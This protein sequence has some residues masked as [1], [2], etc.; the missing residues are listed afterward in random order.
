MGN[1][2][3]IRNKTRRKT[4]CRG[5]SVINVESISQGKKMRQKRKKRKSSTFARVEEILSKGQ[6]ILLLPDPSEESIVVSLDDPPEVQRDISHLSD[7]ILQSIFWYFTLKERCTVLS[8][9]CKRWYHISKNPLFWRDLEFS[10][11]KVPTMTIMQLIRGCPQ[12]R[13]L[14]L[15]RV[16]EAAVIIQELCREKT[17]LTELTLRYCTMN[18]I[19]SIHV[20]LQMLTSLPDLQILDLK[21]TEFFSRRF[22][23]ELCSLKNLKCLNIGAN[24]YLQPRDLMTISVNCKNLESLEL[25]DIPSPSKF[26][27]TDENFVFIITNLRHSLREL[28]FDMQNLKNAAYLVISNCSKLHTLCLTN[29]L[30]LT[31]D[32]FRKFTQLKE[33]KSLTVTRAINLEPKDFTIF[34]DEDLRNIEELN[35]NDCWRLDEV[36]VRSIAKGLPSLK[37]LSLARCTSVTGKNLA[38][39]LKLDT[40]NIANCGVEVKH[41]PDIFKTQKR[42]RFLTIDENMYGA[43][44][45][46]NVSLRESKVKIKVEENT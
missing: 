22:F 27:L 32:L 19:D 46:D 38:S 20:L 2:I 4:G 42:L 24:K 31:G 33:L 16:P 12:L 6:D 41:L 28:K 9:V 36:G 39:C 14:K 23:T 25:L 40:L 3:S 17:E 34:E 26:A 15:F 5:P 29:C 13:S 1:V 44:R 21:G 35:I 18:R 43:A 8:R 7:D 11:S 30:F 45:E 37:R 10:D